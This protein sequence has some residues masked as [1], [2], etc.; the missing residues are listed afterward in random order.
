MRIERCTGDWRSCPCRD[1]VEARAW[2]KQREE[3][4]RDRR[5]R[6]AVSRNFQTTSM[7]LAFQRAG[8]IDA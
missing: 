5:R 4:E 7:R 2:A 6:I 1:C 8:L 3:D